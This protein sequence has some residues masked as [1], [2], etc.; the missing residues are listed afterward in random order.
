MASIFSQDPVSIRRLNVYTP[1]VRASKRDAL[2]SSDDP[3][4]KEYYEAVVQ[5]SIDKVFTDWTTPAATPA[6]KAP[7]LR[8][9]QGQLVSTVVLSTRLHGTLRTK[10]LWPAPISTI[11]TVRERQTADNNALIRRG[12]KP[13][14]G[15]AT[16]DIDAKRARKSV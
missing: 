6:T 15:A 14:P 4:V 8:N 10:S 11:P 5:P 13:N 12:S 1:V 7:L 9:E 3:E 16:V 2:P